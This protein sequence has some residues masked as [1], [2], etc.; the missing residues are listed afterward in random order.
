M[1]FFNF[2]EFGAILSQKVPYVRDTITPE[3][4]RIWQNKYAYKE[5]FTQLGFTKSLHDVDL[6]DHTYKYFLKDLLV[7][8]KELKTVSGVVSGDL[9]CLKTHS[10]YIKL[11]GK[12]LN[13]LM[14]NEK[15]FSIDKT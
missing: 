6:K 2:S 13:S 12:K 11:T 5:D 8:L 9:C 3:T 1:S 15:G 7:L 14:I 4:Y 10:E